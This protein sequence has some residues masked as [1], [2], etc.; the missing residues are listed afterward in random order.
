MEAQSVN[1]VLADARTHAP[2][3]RPI[4]VR[5]LMRFRA[6]AISRSSSYQAIKISGH[7]AI[8]PS[9]YQIRDLSDHQITTIR[10]FT[11]PDRPAFDYPNNS[12]PAA[13]VRQ[14]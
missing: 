2:T 14:R 6:A 9:S 12:G 4:V 3:N 8:R 7:Q 11:Y 5:T 13:A 1:S 10:P